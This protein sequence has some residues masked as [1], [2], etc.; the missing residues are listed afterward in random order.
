MDNGSQSRKNRRSWV[1]WMWEPFEI[2][3]EVL[4]QCFTFSFG[5]TCLDGIRPLLGFHFFVK[6][7]SFWNIFHKIYWRT[8]LINVPCHYWRW[9]CFLICK[10]FISSLNQVRGEESLSNLSS[11]RLVW[12]HLILIPMY[13]LKGAT[14]VEVLVQCLEKLTVC[15]RK[16]RVSFISLQDKGRA[17]CSCLLLS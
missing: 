13:S 17:V 8:V 10:Q 16:W 9:N 7:L 1:R 12:K 3:K 11:F 5:A 14:L 2:H 4:W 6:E 15:G